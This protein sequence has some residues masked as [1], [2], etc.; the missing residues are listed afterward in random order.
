[1]AVLGDT[2]RNEGS[3]LFNHVMTL[4][5]ENIL[6]SFD[7]YVFHSYVLCVFIYENILSTLALWPGMQKFCYLQQLAMLIRVTY[8]SFEGTEPTC[9]WFTHFLNL[10]CPRYFQHKSQA[11]ERVKTFY[12]IHCH[13]SVF[14]TCY[15]WLNITKWKDIT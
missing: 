10:H 9:L 8:C 4:Q 5:L 6:Y 7:V 13:L 1:M 2:C 14:H 3:W 15:G 11:T 12:I